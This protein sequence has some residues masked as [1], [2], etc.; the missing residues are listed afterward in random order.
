MIV[1]VHVIFACSSSVTRSFTAWN[2][3]ASYVRR[4]EVR[5][6][7]PSVAAAARN[8]N[9]PFV[10]LPF[11][12]RKTRIAYVTLTNTRRTSWWR[13]RSSVIQKGLPP[14]RVVT[15]V[16]RPVSSRQARRLRHVILLVTFTILLSLQYMLH[17][18]A[19]RRNTV[20]PESLVR[21]RVRIWAFIL[22]VV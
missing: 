2:R 10:C 1:A 5:A 9:V 18:G 16:S 15:F 7:E 20:F 17:D 6:G 3:D 8:G 13:D 12:L 19:N 14:R 22:K 21:V 4:V 11:Y